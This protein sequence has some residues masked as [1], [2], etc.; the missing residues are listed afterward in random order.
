M[1]VDKA[2][3]N[4]VNVRQAMRLL[5][6]RPQL[7]NSALDGYA[8]PWAADVFSPYDPDFDTSLHRQQDIPQAKYLLKKAGRSR[9]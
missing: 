9:T 2:P 3:F 4:D 8:V 6:N 5:V 1:R 7:I